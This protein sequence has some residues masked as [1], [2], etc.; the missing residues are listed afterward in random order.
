MQVVSNSWSVLSLSCYLPKAASLS[1]AK[2]LRRV[3]G[4]ARLGH[5]SAVQESRTELKLYPIRKTK[6]RQDDFWPCVQ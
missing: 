5:I 1:S 6:D 2:D 3:Q 4:T